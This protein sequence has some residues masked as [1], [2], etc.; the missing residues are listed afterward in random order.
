MSP[1]TPD[2]IRTVRELEAGFRHAIEN[3]EAVPM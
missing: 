2:A 1:V 3:A